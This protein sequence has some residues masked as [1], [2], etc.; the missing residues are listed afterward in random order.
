MMAAFAVPDSVTLTDVE[1][2]GRRAVLV[3]PKGEA[4][5]GTILYLHGGSFALG[6]PGTAM[7]L[8]AH[9]VL[10]T[11]MRAISFDYR[12]APSTPSRRA[13]RTAPRRTGSWWSRVRRRSPSR[14][15]ATLP[16]AP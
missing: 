10:R 2:A 12:L 6:S 13:W 4:R 11:G 15:W 9:L 7:S 3:E 14:W 8:T 16:A 1:L 5:P